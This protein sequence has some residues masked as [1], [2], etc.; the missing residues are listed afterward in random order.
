M[1]SVRLIGGILQGTPWWVY[2][3]LALLV[4]LGLQ[5]TRPRAVAWRRA[6]V[7]PA[8][9]ILWGLTGLL[10]RIGGAPLLAL[11]W[12]A[13][14]ALAGGLA[15]TT[16]RLDL[17]VDRE[18]GVARLPGS[19]VPLLRNLAIFAAKYGLAV[20]L[21]RHLA[22]PATLAIWDV[23]VSGAATGWFLGWVAR[24]GL[25]WRTAP[26]ATLA[27]PEATAVGGRP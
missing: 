18:R 20:A 13:A 22:D 10:P 27:V 17:A 8:V 12:L 1:E 26:G 16:V 4:Y 19:A 9:F 14:A 21:A 6:L 23:A 15:L 11:D 24:F 5:A 3:L 2:A 7:T 25:A